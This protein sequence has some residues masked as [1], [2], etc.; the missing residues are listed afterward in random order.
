[1]TLFEILTN[2]QTG[3]GIPVAYSHFI[4]KDKPKAPPYL[5]YIGDGQD[6]FEADNSYYWKRNRYQLEYYFTKKNEVEETAIESIL[7][8]N[9]FRYEKSEDVYIESEGVFVIYYNI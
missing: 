3:V 8:A 5:V 4:D 7:L 1:M 2:E 6:T 9:G